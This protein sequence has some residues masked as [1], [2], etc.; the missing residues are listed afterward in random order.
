MLR[1][2]PF[3]VQLKDQDFVTA[4]EDGRELALNAGDRLLAGNCV[5]VF[6]LR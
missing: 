5:Y 3:F 1:Y 6:E 4:P 2:A